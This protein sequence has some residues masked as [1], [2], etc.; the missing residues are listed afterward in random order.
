MQLN[1]NEEDP[2]LL[3]AHNDSLDSKQKRKKVR[4]ESY[5]DDEDRV[6]A[7]MKPNMFLVCLNLVLNTIMASFMGIYTWNN[8]DRSECYSWRDS[9]AAI[10]NPIGIYRAKDVTKMFHLWFFWGFVLSVVAILYSVFSIV[11][12]ASRKLVFLRTANSCMFIAL[13]GNLGWTVCGTVF[14]YRHFGM[15]CSG[16]FFND[17][18]YRRIPPF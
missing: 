7:V 5:S 17:E 4:Q 15:V 6:P 12:V 10:E 11:F 14:R 8:P 1:G 18:L 3:L 16:D 13:L 9:S 2:N